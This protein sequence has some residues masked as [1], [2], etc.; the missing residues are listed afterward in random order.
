MMKNI[1][2]I[3]NAII[4]ALT[5]CLFTLLLGCEEGGISGASTQ[6]SLNQSQQSNLGGA[7]RVNFVLGGPSEFMPLPAFIIHDAIDGTINAP[8]EFQTSTS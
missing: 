8:R 7:T 3:P 5:F 2:E 6:G 1:F 4:K